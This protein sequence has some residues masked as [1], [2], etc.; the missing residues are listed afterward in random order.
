MRRL[1]LFTL[2]IS[3]AFLSFA[4]DNGPKEITP[5]LLQK[6]NIE[7]ENLI[8]AYKKLLVDREFNVDETEFSIDTFRIS[9][10]VSK[11]MDIDYSTIGINFTVNEMTSAYDKLMNKYYNKLLKALRPEDKKVLINA[12]RAWLAF[13]NAEEKFIG[14]M[15]KEVYSGGGTIQS[16]IATGAYSDLVVQRTI[17]LFEYY[18]GIQKQ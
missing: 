2:F 9:Q 8:P 13:R 14:T 10:T 15:T 7:V 5:Q 11:R 1:F 6:I 16:T 18:N 12:Q 4:Q 3:L 17:E